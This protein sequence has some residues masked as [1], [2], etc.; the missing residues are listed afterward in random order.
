M[1]VLLTQYAA[2]NLWA[3]QKIIDC[4]KNLPDEKINREIISSFPS[5]YK[6]ILHMFDAECMWWQRLKLVEY[7]ERPSESFKDNFDELV[8]LYFN[9]SR[10]WDEWVS[11]ASEIQLCH[12][13]A[14]QNTKKEQ[15]KQ[16]VYEMLMHLFNHTTYHRGQLITF[17]RQLNVEK[18]PPTDYIVFCRKK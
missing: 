11:G 18:I 12:V 4:I 17:L 3:N 16:P 14:Y 2:Y 13:F 8:K 6:T 9:Q 1:K 15:F 7:V 10:Q 5:I